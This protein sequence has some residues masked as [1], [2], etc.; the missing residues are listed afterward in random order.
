MGEFS[1][2]DYDKLALSLAPELAKRLH[3]GCPMGWNEE[4][5]Q[6]LSDF[7][8]SLRKIKSTVLGAVVYAIMIFLLGA[9]AMGIKMQFR[10]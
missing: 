8:A 2:I 7:A 3:I 1:E 9:L 5:I 10:P 4:D 6:T